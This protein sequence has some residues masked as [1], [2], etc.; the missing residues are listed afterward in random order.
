[1]LFGR[2]SSGQALTERV[3]TARKLWNGGHTRVFLH[4]LQA[5]NMEGPGQLSDS[6]KQKKQ[7][8]RFP[9]VIT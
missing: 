3:R 7:M 5:S 1:M 4:L 2:A 6:F 8:P 9:D